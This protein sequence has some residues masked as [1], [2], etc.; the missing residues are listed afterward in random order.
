[1][2]RSAGSYNE[3]QLDIVGKSFLQMHA[4]SFRDLKM[5]PG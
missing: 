3:F 1:M 4:E 2:V 5:H